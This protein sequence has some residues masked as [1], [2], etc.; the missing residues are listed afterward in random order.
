MHVG[1]GIGSPADA[2]HFRE[3]VSVPVEILPMEK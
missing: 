3:K 2:E 1:G